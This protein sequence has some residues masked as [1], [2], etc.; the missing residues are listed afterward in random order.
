MTGTQL[1][2]VPAR[3]APQAGPALAA[4][5]LAL[6]AERQGW[7]TRKE[8]AGYGFTPRLCRLARQHSKGRVIAGQRGFRASQPAGRTHVY[9]LTRQSSRSSTSRFRHRPSLH[10]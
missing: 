10:R 7:L 5:L 3:R 2:L 6:L 4:R 8:L 1:E 9:G